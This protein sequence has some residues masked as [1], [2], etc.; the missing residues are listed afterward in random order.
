MRI[1]QEDGAYQNDDGMRHKCRTRIEENAYNNR[2]HRHRD[3]INIRKVLLYH[4]GKYY[5]EEDN[6][7]KEKEYTSF[8]FIV[9]LSEKFQINHETKY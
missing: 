6:E 8:T 9:I 7:S 3:Y 2:Y 1:A 5:G 4:D